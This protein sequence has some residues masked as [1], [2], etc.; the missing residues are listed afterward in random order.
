MTVSFNKRDPIYLQVI[1][2]F[3][4]KIV[5]GSLQPGQEVPSRRELANKLKINPNTVQRAYK[6]MEEE[7]LLFTEGNMPSRITED[8]KILA[9]LRTN[10]IQQAV[11]EFVT[12]IES[13]QIPTSEVLQIVEEKLTQ[14]ND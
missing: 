9:Q 11:E 6:E 7:K 4:E 13:I 14:S 5:S 1:Q 3:K 10:M 2:L 12:A 8:T